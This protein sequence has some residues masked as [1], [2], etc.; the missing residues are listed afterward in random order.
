MAKTKTKLKTK[1]ESD[2]IYKK[3]LDCRQECSD[4]YLDTSGK[5]NKAKKN[6]L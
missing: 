6:V 3:V 2:A 4:K 1:K 5:K